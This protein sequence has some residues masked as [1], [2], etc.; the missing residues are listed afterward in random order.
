[1]LKPLARWLHRRPLAGLVG[2]LGDRTIE[3]L[4]LKAF[5]TT[6]DVGFFAIAGGLFL[7]FLVYV[8]GK[9]VGKK[10]STVV[11]IRRI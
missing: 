3:V 4:L 7:L 1:M 11:E 2:L 9:R 6:Q 8:I 10:K 5:S